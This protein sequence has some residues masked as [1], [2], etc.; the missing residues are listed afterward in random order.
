MNSRAMNGN[1]G[2]NLAFG[3]NNQYDLYVQEIEGIDDYYGPT[4]RWVF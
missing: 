3:G 2:K 4:F 1:N